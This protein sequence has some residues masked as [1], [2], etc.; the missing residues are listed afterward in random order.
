MNMTKKQQLISAMESSNLLHSRISD[1]SA[2][3]QAFLDFQALVCKLL[4][5]KPYTDRFS[6][7]LSEYQTKAAAAGMSHDPSIRNGLQALDQL[8]K[9]LRMTLSGFY[10]EQ[11]VQNTLS[12]VSRSIK[13]WH[14]VPISE[15]ITISEIDHLV[16][17]DNGLILLETKNLSTAISISPEGYL[18]QDGNTCH[19][20]EPIGDKICEKERIL[21]LY[22]SN[23]LRRLGLDIPVHIESFLVFSNKKNERCPVTDDYHQQR[24]C[25]RSRLHYMVQEFVTSMTYSSEQMA[26]IAEIL[27]NMS[28]K[29]RTFAADL[30]FGVACNDLAEMAAKLTPEEAIT[31]PVVV[32]K[33]ETALEIHKTGNESKQKI[34][35]I[36]PRKRFN[37]VPA[38]ACISAAISLGIFTAWKFVK[39]A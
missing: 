21:K 7:L 17:T 33:P 26:V 13:C 36:S 2:Y 3:S 25:F 10:A 22:L 30:D 39:A 35:K 23:E 18:L 1:F 9:S 31:E 19:H 32:K 38:A 14:N 20:H 34:Q 5:D 6:I 27:D 37:F 28:L 12:Y 4:S 11:R 16:L 8:D 29:Q 24:W 15:G